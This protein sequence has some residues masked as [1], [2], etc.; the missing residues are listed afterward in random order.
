MNTPAPAPTR[1][2][3]WFNWLFWSWNVI[4]L[5]FMLFGFV[6]QALPQLIAEVQT[7]VVRFQFLLYA[8]VLSVIPL[9]AVWLGLTRLRRSPERLFALGYV[10]EGPMMLILAIR[11]FVIRQASAG[12]VALFCIVILGMVAFLWHILDPEV[13][14]RGRLAGWLRLSGLTLMLLSSLYAAAWIAF[15]TLPLLGTAF[16]WLANTL[17]D[18]AGF[19]RN[20]WPAL[21]DLLRNGGLWAPFF[22]LGFILVLY[23]AT[24]FGLAP[25]AIP[26]LSW[27]AWRSAWKALSAR[28][29]WPIPAIL[30]V[31][32]L[33]ISGAGFVL[34]NRQPQ[35]QAF[36]L[37]ATPPTSIQQAQELAKRSGSIRSGLLNAYLAP[38]R[39]M[40]AQGEVRHVSE[41]YRNIF[42]MSPESA[43]K[44]Q[45]LYETLARPLVYEPVHAPS[46]GQ[47]GNSQA[48]VDD[49]LEA[50]RLYLRLFDVPIDEGERQ[51]V[52]NAARS[53]WS[54]AQAEAALLAMDEREVYLERQ[55]IQVTE[56]GDWAEVEL[57]ETYRN[58]TA[59]EHEVVYYFS[60]PESAVVTGLWLGSSSD[61]EKR[62]EYQVA[63]RGAAQATYRNEVRQVRDPALLEQ[64]GP[65]QYRLRVYPIPAREFIWTDDG[66]RVME[67]IANPQSM[68]MTYRVLAQDSTWPLPRMA[69]NINV[70]WD[71]NTIRLVNGSPMDMKTEDWLPGS[72]PAMQA[73]QPTAHRFDLPG[74]TSIL[75]QPAAPFDLAEFN[76]NLRLAVILD[77]SK[78]M[79]RVSDLVTEALDRLKLLAG[80]QPVDVYLSSSPFRGEKPSRLRLAELDTQEMFYFGGQNAAQ[81][82]NQYASLKGSDLYDGILILTDGSGYEPGQGWLDVSAPDA[83]VWLVHLGGEFPLGYDDPT[84]EAI[85][86][87]GGG[88]TGDLDS[89]LQRLSYFTSTTNTS[90]EMSDLL[91]GYQ[92]RVLPTAQAEGSGIPADSPQDG[93]SALAARALILAEMHRQRGSLADLA[94]LD[95]LHALAVNYSVVSPY[96]SMIVLVNRQQEDILSHLSQGDDRFEREQEAL[97]DTTPATDVPLTGVP[98]PH[99][100]LLIG[101]AAA[102]L[103]YY[104]YSRREAAAE[105]IRGLRD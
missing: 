23:T 25:I 52:I 5:A 95:R 84:L 45:S 71:K 57:F 103:M 74:G 80:N 47:A 48:L 32:V 1:R 50:S 70:F 3:K 28:S 30:V 69:E 10:V 56:Y 83:P 37:L 18:L 87:S 96:S 9:L 64:I 82:L 94:T 6:P 21:E 78:S 88:V 26:V 27:Q 75:V 29:G 12:L 42:G 24:L 101:L 11:F 17:R 43:Y 2:E 39:Y 41:L 58:Q 86:A 85:Q 102:I 38:Y 22:I 93:F 104:A 68:W 65:R 62:F 31:T 35:K 67:Q 51:T 66:G 55:E 60:L 13:E 14:R 105:T 100:W 44:V 4:F 99:E 90:Q 61:R 40:S 76:A 33:V 54:G 98:E 89:A 15:Y 79:E 46:P 19:W 53:T 72:L 7:G 36:E 8:A 73:V 97:G 59:E 20:L 16:N 92:W 49:P 81:L 77:R 91:D 34:A 63:P